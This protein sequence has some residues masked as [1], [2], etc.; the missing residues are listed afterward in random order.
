MMILLSTLV[1]TNPRLNREQV[2]V[3][4]IDRSQDGVRVFFLED[5][6]L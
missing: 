4:Q 6:A 5:A 1:F 2:K 3:K